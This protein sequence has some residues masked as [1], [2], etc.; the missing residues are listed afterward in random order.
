MDQRVTLLDSRSIEEFQGEKSVT[1][2]K[3]HIPTA[4]PFPFDANLSSENT[5]RFINF[6]DLE[7]HFR[8]I[9]RD[10]R[11]ITYCNSGTRASVNYLALRLLG[12]D[13]AV[14]DGSWIEWSKTPD[15]PI[16]VPYGPEPEPHPK[17]EKK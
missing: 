1:E 16:G 9:P 11:V 15:A 13:A 10:N 2:K 6:A 3:G 4:L 12:Y 5:C 14:Y 8:S 7:R 17:D